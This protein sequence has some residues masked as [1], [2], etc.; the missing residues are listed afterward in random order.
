[1]KLLPQSLLLRTAL[2]V[3]A[4]LVLSQLAS[5][6]LLHEYVTRPRNA[7]GM[8]QFVSHLKTISAALQ[9]MAPEQQQEFIGRIAEKEGIRI[10]LARGNERMRPAADVPTVNMFRE[11]VREIF[12]AEAEVYVR[13][14]QEAPEESGKRPRPQVL[15]I[16]LPAGERDFWVAFPR[17]RIERD[18]T[19]ALVAWTVAGLAIAALATFFIV[20][21]LNQPLADLARAA[22]RLGGG[23]DPPPV[24]ETGPSEVRA[25]QR[26]FNR[27]QEG[28]QKSRSDRAT[29]LAGVSHD[30]RT[31]LSRLRLEL[32]MQEGRMEP[33]TLNAMGADLEDMNAIIDQFMDFMRSEASE[34]LSPVSLPE[35]AR[36]CA[37]RA[38]RSGTP[39]SCELAEMPALMLRPLAMQRG[40]D[41]LIGNAI[42]HAPGS[43]IVVR[44]GEAEGR[45]QVSVLDRGPGIPPEMVERLKEPFTR[46]DE[47]RSGSSGAGLGLAIASRVAE[48]HGG[49]LDLVAR[50]GG[51][52]EARISLPIAH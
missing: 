15:W 37:E 31:P 6:Y 38:A 4:A 12:G 41:N 17:G 29:F 36:S 24:E 1:M 7:F 32:E 25:V 52:L 21:R 35:L 50:D 14:G 2:V 47:S 19:S 33:A 13:G 5:L 49:R 22:D 48:I 51:G 34:P 11:R 43:A 45:A 30:L 16:K 3:A 40:V 23:A 9:T 18:P 28:L 8:G 46:R 20:W 27:M 42:R 44:V 10:S 26:A 39:I